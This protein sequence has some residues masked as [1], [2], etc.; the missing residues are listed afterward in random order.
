MM[1]AKNIAALWMVV[2]PTEA[3]ELCDVYWHQELAHLELQ[4]L[5]MGR[6]AWE[7]SN[8]LFYAEE[9]SA[10]ADA[11]ARIA[12]RDAAS[13]VRAKAAA[14]S[15]ANEL[16][17]ETLGEIRKFLGA[18]DGQDTMAALREACRK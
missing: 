17:L 13:H 8:A 2:N 3:S 14:V 6:E 9:A 10:K 12:A 1:E 18:K 4:I 11:V 5:G 15:R 7:K 16:A